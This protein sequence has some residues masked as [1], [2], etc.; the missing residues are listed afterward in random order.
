MLPYLEIT[1]INEEIKETVK[2][3]NVTGITFKEAKQKLKDAGIETNSSFEAD[4]IITNQLPKEGINIESG[5]NVILY[6]E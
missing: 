2:M 5:T 4:T 6:G 1:K 3:P